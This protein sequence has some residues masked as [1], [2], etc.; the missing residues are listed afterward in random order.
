MQKEMILLLLLVGLPVIFVLNMSGATTG[1]LANPNSQLR[2]QRINLYL[3]FPQS[4]DNPTHDQLIYRVRNGLRLSG[5]GDYYTPTGL[6]SGNEYFE[7]EHELFHNLLKLACLKPA[8]LG[9]KY[10]STGGISVREHGELL[11]F[12]TIGE[13]PC[14][15]ALAAAAEQTVYAMLAQD[16]KLVLNTATNSNCPSKTYDVLTR[17]K[18]NIEAGDV[19]AATTNLRAAWNRATACA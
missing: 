12:E 13:I 16:Y 1:M 8:P 7:R 19:E 3:T 10:V 6:R 9:G 14:D 18:Q 4:S 17:A 5:S 11:T 2:Q 15:P